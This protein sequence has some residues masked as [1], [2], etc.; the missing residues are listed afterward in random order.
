MNHA[1]VWLPEHVVLAIHLHERHFSGQVAADEFAR[2]TGK[3]TTRSAMIGKWNR[4]GLRAGK[5]PVI[6]KVRAPEK[7]KAVRMVPSP[8]L[9]SPLPVETE[10]RLSPQPCTII[11]LRFSDQCRWVMSETRQW[12]IYY[13]GATREFSGE[14]APHMY[15]VFHA[16]R[17]FAGK[18]RP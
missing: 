5:E 16:A 1:T 11:E 3:P 10:P 2:L 14:D 12:P 18:G 13:C 8:P 15:C 9:S 6:K 4:L 17:A 7:K